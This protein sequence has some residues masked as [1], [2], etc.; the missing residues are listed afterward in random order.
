MIK[1]MTEGNPIRLIFGFALPI[2]LSSIVQQFYQI[3]DT[4]IVG[5][6]VGVSAL[7]AVGSCGGIITMVLGWANGLTSGF[8]ILISKSFGSRD[9]K[10]MSEYF[11]NAVLLCAMIAVGMTAA[12]QLILPWLVDVVN[13][14]DELR[15]DVTMYIRITFWGLAGSFLYNLLSSVQR[16]MGDSRT[17]LIFLGIS[18]VANLGMDILFV[19]PL[20]MGV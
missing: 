14:P 12:L 5:Q 18:V 4:M 2:M 9:Y 7:A 17:P 13:T 6:F 10:R 11:M 15:A 8:S 3:T 16:A 20:G 1:N 19:G